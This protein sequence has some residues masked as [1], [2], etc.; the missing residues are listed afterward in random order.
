MSCDQ[1]GFPMVDSGLAAEIEKPTE[2]LVEDSGRWFV[3]G[4][5]RRVREVEGLRE[6][7][8]AGAAFLLTNLRKLREATREDI[9]QLPKLS[10]YLSRF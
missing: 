9:A 8:L 6:A 1:T 2:F 10:E 7:E 5:T 4:E 3:Y